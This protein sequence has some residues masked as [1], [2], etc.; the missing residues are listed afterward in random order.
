ML[1]HALS[2]YRYV[3][4]DDP[5]LR[6]LAREDPALFL[7]THPPPLIIDEVQ[8]VPELLIYLKILIDGAR[9]QKGQ[10]V[11]TCPQVYQLM[12]GVS[13]SLAG[14]I[15]LFHLYPLSWEEIDHIPNR[16][17][18]WQDEAHLAQAILGGFYPEPLRLAETSLIPWH[19][20][21]LS[22]YLERDVRNLRAVADL[23]RFQTFMG[24]LALRAG[25][26]LN[27]AEVAKECGINQTTAKDWLTILRATY[28]I[29]LLP[30][31]AKTAAS[32]S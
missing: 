6:Q 2:E 5:K 26:L 27:I 20:S 11:L 4:F 23:D 25:G 32:G 22:T 7:D 17:G 15:A 12:E 19:G 29:Y 18:T 21:Y 10:Y 14:R 1:S 9:E 24:L 3:S 31:I 28:I 16:K 8:Y 30:P 13:E